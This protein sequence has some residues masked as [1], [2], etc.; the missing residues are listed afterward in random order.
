MARKKPKVENE[1]RTDLFE[2]WRSMQLTEE[3]KAELRAKSE[4]NGEEAAR[5][6]LWEMFLE[7]EGQN[8]GAW[9]FH[10]KMRE[11]ED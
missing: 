6:G 10:R 4:R 5:N 2:I 8:P 9:E 11:E 7:V 3:E 1:P